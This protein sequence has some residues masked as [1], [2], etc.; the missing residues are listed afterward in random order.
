MNEQLPA[1]FAD[2]FNPPL[3]PPQD[4]PI[5]PRFQGRSSSLGN[6]LPAEIDLGQPGT[7]VESSPPFV[8]FGADTAMEPVVPSAVQQRRDGIP[9]DNIS[10]DKQDIAS[11]IAAVLDGAM[12]RQNPRQISTQGRSDIFRPSD[13]SNANNF[14]QPGSVGHPTENIQ[15]QPPPSTGNEMTGFG[16]PTDFVIDLPTGTGQT[17]KEFGSSTGSG[18]IPIQQ[19]SETGRQVFDTPRGSANSGSN[20][21]SENTRRD[22]FGSSS[23]SGIGSPVIPLDS[24]AAADAGSS[25]HT[26]GDHP[27]RQ[28]DSWRQRSSG[29]SS[30]GSDITPLQDRVQNSGRSR[31][32]ATQNNVG[33]IS[34]QDNSNRLRSTGNNIDT[35]LELIEPVIPGTQLNERSSSGRSSSGSG[36]MMRQ[37]E[38]ARQSR[39]SALRNQNIPVNPPLPPP[40]PFTAGGIDRGNPQPK[41]TKKLKAMEHSRKAPAK[42]I[43]DKRVPPP[44]N[45]KPLK[46]HEKHNRKTNKPT[47]KETPRKTAIS[48]PIIGVRT[49]DAK[50]PS[51]I[52]N[53]N[54]KELTDIV[55]KVLLAV[56]SGNGNSA[57]LPLSAL[58]ATTTP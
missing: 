9:H 32:G 40:P 47:R 58:S 34:N 1:E 36:S 31:F 37:G 41:I 39:G 57:G 33:A 35:P 51:T 8:Q 25:G 52:R 30:D 28:R 11:G 5:A 12:L 50:T 55:V 42:V 19:A 29:I 24:T 38:S 44:K 18:S 53:L 6:N 3:V 46:H 15:S 13:P 45:R 23:N 49:S 54:Q 21:R 48:I 10:L 27:L 14:D 16:T 2:P 17:R 56:L 26:V 20:S 4:P 22:R 43:E 7:P